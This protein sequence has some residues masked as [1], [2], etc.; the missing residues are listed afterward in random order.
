[1]NNEL[2]DKLVKSTEKKFNVIDT[3]KKQLADSTHAAIMFIKSHPNYVK[4]IALHD[5]DHTE[6]YNVVSYI[7]NKIGKLNEKDL[8]ISLLKIGVICTD[9]HFLICVTLYIISL[10]ISMCINS[11]VINNAEDLLWC[12]ITS[13]PLSL[14][15]SFITIVVFYISICRKKV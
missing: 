2:Y 13:L 6:Y 12:L 14:L 1:M 5:D 7:E 10:I 11:I 8:R 9:Y 4:Q 3:E 15:I